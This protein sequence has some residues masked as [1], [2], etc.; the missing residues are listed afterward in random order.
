MIRQQAVPAVTPLAGGAAGND[1]L[2]RWSTSGTPLRPPPEV[3]AAIAPLLP[4]HDETNPIL[5]LGVTPELAI[6]PR[7]TI[8]VDRNQRMI[9]GAWLGDTAERRVVRGAWQHL[10]LADHSVAGAIGDGSLSGLIFPGGY[11]DMFDELRRVIRPGGRAVF[12]CFVTPEHWE[13]VEETG[14]AA[15]TGGISFHVFKLRFNEAVARELGGPN[16]SSDQACDRFREL[17]PDRDSLVRSSGWSLETIAE[18]DRYQGCPDNHS[19]PTRSE[20]QA[21]LGDKVR[22]LRFVEVPGYA[23]AERCPLLV[24]EF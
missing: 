7:F 18:M 21:A 5:L 15:L 9:D 23:L 2:A 4:P 12:R 19:Y 6:L 3:P 10:P 1:F 16:V 8:A 17:F 24:A 11:R 20:L 13:S 14:D 22:S